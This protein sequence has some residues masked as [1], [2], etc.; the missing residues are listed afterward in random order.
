MNT[1][2][3]R[4]LMDGCVRRCVRGC[5][6]AC[7]GAW[8]RGRVCGFVCV[9]LLLTGMCKQLLYIIVGYCGLVSLQLVCQT[10]PL[11]K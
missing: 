7:V 11:G 9:C 8:V 10:S 5:V 3:I 2:I 1:V 6:G 4:I